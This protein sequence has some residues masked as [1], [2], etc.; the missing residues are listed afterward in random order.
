MAIHPAQVPVIQRGADPDRRPRS[1]RPAPSSRRSPAIPA[2]VAVAIDGVMY[3]R[4]HL[5]ARP[6]IAGA[7]GVS[8]DCLTLVISSGTRRSGSNSRS[9]SRNFERHGAAL[10]ERHRPIEA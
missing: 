3:D 2:R 1:P 5:E 7:R 8:R 9:A 10:A 4:P 6:A